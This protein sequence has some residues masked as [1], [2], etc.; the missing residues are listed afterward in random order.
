MI[1]SSGCGAGDCYSNRKCCPSY[2]PYYC[3]VTN[4]CHES[5]QDAMTKSQGACSSF[6]VSC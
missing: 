2:A 1:R 5:Q 6:K 4:R 3:H